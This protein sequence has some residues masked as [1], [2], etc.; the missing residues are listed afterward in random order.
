MK[1]RAEKKAEAEEIERYIE[2][3]KSVKGMVIQVLREN[4]DARNSPEWTCHIVRR[5]CAE[6]Y[7]GKELHELS[8]DER[9]VLPK[10]SSINRAMR[11]IQND[12]PTQYVPDE[13]VE[14]SKEAK[15]K[16]MHKNFG[17][18]RDE[19]VRKV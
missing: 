7:F 6:E 5:E 17:G 10:S 11:T 14:I 1:T 8:K 2:K 18:S 13:D 9:L 16:A 12:E 19:G 4:P 3:F 15:R